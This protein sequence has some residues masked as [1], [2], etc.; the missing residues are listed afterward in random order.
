MPGILPVEKYRTTAL[1]QYIANLLTPRAKSSLQLLASAESAE[2]AACSIHTLLL[3]QGFGRT[4]E[5]FCTISV[6]SIA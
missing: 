5:Y 2:K 3:T 6:F 1:E 4:L